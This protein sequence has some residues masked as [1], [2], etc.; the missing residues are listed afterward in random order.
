MIKIVKNIFATEVT[1]A[2]EFLRLKKSMESSP[3]A[4][5]PAPQMLIL[6]VSSFYPSV[7][8]LFNLLKFCKGFL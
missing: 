4:G 1:E 7:L 2:T 8:L 5:Y 6:S 3:Q